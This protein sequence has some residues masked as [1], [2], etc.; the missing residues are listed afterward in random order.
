MFRTY[1]GLNTKLHA[2]YNA[3]HSSSASASIKSIQG[4]LNALP[5]N[6]ENMLPQIPFINFN[7]RNFY[8]LRFPL[9]SIEQVIFV[10]QGV[11]QPKP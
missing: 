4:F 1:R 3:L 8:F 2:L 6:I 9:A 11:L 5:D 7:D 10:G